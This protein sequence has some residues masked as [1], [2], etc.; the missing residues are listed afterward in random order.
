[1]KHNRNCDWLVAPGIAYCPQCLQ[2]VIVEETVPDVQ[3]APGEPEAP[4]AIVT[5]QACGRNVVPTADS[6]CPWDG[7]LLLKTPADSRPSVSTPDGYRSYFGE[8][9]L[10]LGRLSEDAPLGA[11]VNRDGVSRRHAS[12][13]L[14]AEGIVWLRD[15]GS[16]NGTWLAGRRLGAEA[17][18]P[19]GDSEIGLGREMTVTVH[20]P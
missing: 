10:T 4:A 14:D 1:M 12:I 6:T 5:C 8:T 15:L 9:P 7:E 11:A 3:E 20:V 16:T 17:R 18:L 13:R 2:P 19:P